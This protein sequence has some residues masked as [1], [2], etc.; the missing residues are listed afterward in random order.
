MVDRGRG[1]A[2]A[3]SLPEDAMACLMRRQPIQRP[4]PLGRAFEGHTLSMAFAR[5]HHAPPETTDAIL[6]KDVT[7]LFRGVPAV[8]R[9]SFSLPRGRVLGLL[10][11]NGAG[12]TTTVGMI[13][14]LIQQDEGRIEVLGHA[15]PDARDQVLG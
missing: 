6:L 3:V 10:G 4:N 5:T 7:K 1:Q 15:I 13:M 9:V 11:G 8:D 2:L 12:K 14:G